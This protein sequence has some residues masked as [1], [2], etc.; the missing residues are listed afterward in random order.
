V[1]YPSVTLT[2]G[3]G[4]QQPLLQE[5]ADPMTTA[6]WQT[7]VEIHPETAAAYGIREHE[8][9]RVASPAGELVLP[10]VI[11]PG[12][13]PDVVAIP[14]GRGQ[15]A[16]GRFAADRGATPV[17]LLVAA[18]TSHFEK[19]LWNSTMVQLEATGRMGQLARLESLEG[20]G[21]ESI[22]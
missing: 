22:R 17:D 21:R 8:L 3:R 5:V 14:L 11:Y 4:A 9:V 1:I 20:E 13:R 2:A 10:A 19:L 12:I 15:T 7:W 16:G 18:P 6:Q